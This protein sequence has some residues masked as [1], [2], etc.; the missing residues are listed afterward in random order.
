VKTRDL[1]VVGGAFGLV[2]LLAAC[3][4]TSAGTH[5]SADPTASAAT[6]MSAS[7]ADISFAQLMI[8]H[9]QQAMQMA[10]L[11][12]ANASSSDVLQLAEQ[13]KAA[14]D[15]E[16][17]IMS[18]WL[19]SWDAPMQMEGSDHGDM[20][21]GGITMSGMMSDEDMQQLATAAG[22]DFDSMWLQMM[23]THHQGAV[24]MAEQVRTASGNAEVKALADAVISG[25]TAEIEAMQ[26]LL[27]E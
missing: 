10:D 18:G 9:H 15:P 25:Q 27:A 11:A 8:P 14:Q 6:L 17:Q 4:S 12:L 16:V 1:A 26:D 2:L 23:I 3:G 21:M 5:G 19:D 7:D 22:A 24:S 20:D 13:I